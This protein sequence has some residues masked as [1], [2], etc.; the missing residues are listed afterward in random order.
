MQILTIPGLKFN[1]VD[2]PPLNHR[3]MLLTKDNRL[4]FGPWK[5]EAPGFNKSLKAWSGVPERCM[6]TERQLGFK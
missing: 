3:L 5:G 2:M 4:E 6:E 1:Y